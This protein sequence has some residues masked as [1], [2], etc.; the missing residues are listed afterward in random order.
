MTIN[1]VVENHLDNGLSNRTTPTGTVYRW[2]LWLLFIPLIGWQ[3]ASTAGAAP[4]PQ[5][6]SPTTAPVEP[7]FTTYTT[8][9]GLPDDKIWTIAFDASGRAW[10]G[11]YEGS[12]SSLDGQTWTSYPVADVYFDP[13]TR[14][15][16]PMANGLAD[17]NVKTILPTPDGRV[18]F[19]TGRGLSVLDGQQWQSYTY[20][21]DGL[22]SSG[23]ESLALEAD[24]TLWAAHLAE[25][26]SRFD[27]QRWT[28]YTVAD[29]LADNWVHAVAVDREGQ[30]W[31][32]T[33]GG[34]SVYSPA[35]GRWT[36]YTTAAGLVDNTVFAAAVTPNGH[37]WFGT[38]AGLS[39]FDG[40][41]WTTHLAGQPITAL[42]VDAAG[43]LWAVGGG[44][45]S[46]FDG[47][48]W[49]TYLPE[50]FAGQ[51]LRA[52]SVSPAGQVWVGS[53]GAGLTVFTP[54]D[55]VADFKGEWQTSP[56]DFPFDLTLT[57]TGTQL[58]GWHCGTLPDASRTDCLPAGSAEYS[59][60]GAIQGTT[61]EVQIT[62]HYG[63]GVGHAVLTY[64]NG[65]LLWS[66]VEPPEGEFY[67]PQQAALAPKAALIKP[68]LWQVLADQGD[69]FTHLTASA[70][71]SIWAIGGDALVHFDGLTWRS[72]DLPEA[73]LASIAA[74][75]SILSYPITDLA[76][77][78]AGTVWVAT[79]TDG[80]YRFEEGN[81]Q[82]V[83]L[84]E[85]LPALAVMRLTVDGS[86]RL[87]AIFK[88]DETHTLARFEDQGWR[89]LALPATDLAPNGVVVTPAGQVWL[90]VPGKAPYLFN[91]QQWLQP[92]EGWTAGSFELYLAGSPA[93][94]VWFGG[95]NGWLRWSGDGWQGLNVTLPAPFA[96]PAAVDSNGGA[97]GIVTSFCYWCKLPNFNENGV[98]YATPEQSCRFTAADGLGDPALDP[99]P[100]PF[101]AEPPRPD[102][103]RDVAVAADGRVWFITQGKLT[104]FSPQDQVCAYARPENVR[105]AK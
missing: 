70:T 20:G 78:D 103:V 71:G 54:P 45:V 49:T 85:G 105:T 42:A 44:Q 23:I 69:N 8:A 77:T 31:F 19:G 28:T 48:A 95:D 11:T 10:I 7:T 24:G 56:P 73:L 22:A 43:R 52:V 64:T 27:G 104:V 53:F 37:K 63:G 51:D 40:Q 36:V 62:S 38:S 32:G 39:Q 96:F 29:G 17:A 102:A 55:A 18:W 66:L 26:V 35:E 94:G 61:A 57:Q 16:Q 80:L 99:S 74:N 97:W 88:Q 5:D 2:L 46:R 87:W 12:V 68:P 3:A 6:S 90:S 72:F 65:A 101:T 59:V 1:A 14:T 75:A 60:V 86:N 91:G 50:H 21:R 76:V 89:P 67:L 83:S 13:P 84:A 33:N 81:W 25:G 93:G 92:A 79:R 41:Q 15:L 98:V 58:Q 4:L 9:N 82:H 34:V 100:N 30:V 47:A